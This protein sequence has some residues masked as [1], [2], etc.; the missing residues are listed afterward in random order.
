MTDLDPDA[1]AEQ[2]EQATKLLTDRLLPVDILSHPRLKAA[3]LRLGPSW[4]YVKRSL[5][6]IQALR[7]HLEASGH[8]RYDSD[9]RPHQ[10]AP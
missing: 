10:P 1:A 5:D 8:V 6:D 3:V 2:I 7:N 4:A 9:G